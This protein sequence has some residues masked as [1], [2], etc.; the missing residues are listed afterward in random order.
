MSTYN[1]VVAADETTNSLAPAVRARLATEMADPTSEVGGVVVIQGALAF[2]VKDYGATGDGTTDDTTA[3][4]ATLDACNTA[5]GGVVFLPRGT[6]K[7]TAT[8]NPAA[9]VSMVGT[10]ALSII[11]VSATLKLSAIFANASSG[12]TFADFAIVGS[13]QGAQ[14]ANVAATPTGTDAGCGLIL[15]GASAVTVRGL[16]VSA[17]GGTTGV[18]PYNGVAGIW[19]TYGTQNT[20]VTGCHVSTS[21]NGINEDNFFVADP[22]G[23]KIVGNTVDACRF[24]IALDSSGAATDTLVS[25][26]TVT[27]S[28][29]SGVDLN[30]AQL[31]RVTGNYIENVGIES[32]NSGVFFYAT[33]GIP[34][35]DVVI[36]GNTIKASNGHGVKIGPYVY[37]VNVSDNVIISPV[38]NGIYAQGTCRY[39][40]F[41]NNVVHSPTESG[42]V[43]STTGGLLASTG[44]VSGNMLRDCGHYGIILDGVTGVSVTGNVIDGASITTSNTYD[45]IRLTNAVTACVFTGNIVNATTC[46]YTIAGVDSGSNGNTFAGNIFGTGVTGRAGFANMYQFW[47]NNADNFTSTGGTPAG[48]YPNGAQVYNNGDQKIYV[49]GSLGWRSVATV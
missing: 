43:L 18:A 36:S 2:N 13:G 20:T 46:R 29:Q 24:G 22:H 3:I 1:R 49:R 27:N 48:T 34:G 45:G 35:Y 4:Q 25:G 40:T 39:Y 44:A 12:T 9:N 38:K 26:N 17:C 42:I 16:H 19:L 8:L 14:P 5:G 37:R 33:S 28:Q 7:C 6:Y 21:R 30:K 15:A 32:G 11:D 31:V 10:G 23:N 47:S 41:S